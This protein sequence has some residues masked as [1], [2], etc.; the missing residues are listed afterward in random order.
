[1]TTVEFIYTA[2]Q[3]WIGAEKRLLG[4]RGLIDAAA[5]AVWTARGL[6]RNSPRLPR[7]SPT[8]CEGLLDMVAAP[9]PV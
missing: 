3:G 5:K 9:G 2:W 4:A 6:T 1:M 7:S 8:Y